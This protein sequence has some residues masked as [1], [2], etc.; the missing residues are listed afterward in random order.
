MTF[1]SVIFKQTEVLTHK[2]DWLDGPPQDWFYLGAVLLN[3]VVINF[4][5]AVDIQSSQIVSTFWNEFWQWVFVLSVF[6][7]EDD[8]VARE[9]YYNDMKTF[10]VQE[11]SKP[12]L[13]L[14]FSQLGFIGVFLCVYMQY[15]RRRSYCTL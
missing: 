8:I 13:Y 9:G 3:V 2:P 7:L 14:E 10:A 15:A 11:A 1:V 4:F 6:Q 5:S 12:W